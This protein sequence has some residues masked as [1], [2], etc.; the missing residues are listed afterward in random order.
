MNIAEINDETTTV[1][2][3]EK[4]PSANPAD[5]QSLLAGYTEPAK[6]EQPLTPPTTPAPSPMPVG[7]GP[8]SWHGNPMYYQTGKKAGQ[9][10]PQRKQSFLQQPANV[11]VNPGVSEISGSII[12]GAL[13]LTIINLLFPMLFSVVNNMVSKKKI[14]FEDL[15]IDDKTLKQLD[16]LS[17]KA[18]K[19]I[20]IEANPVAVLLVTMV[21][22][23]AMQ[24]MTVRM[25]NDIEAKNKM[26]V[27]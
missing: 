14:A 19:H 22:L 1:T 6:V 26:K 18:L 2:E 13:F 27:A 20:K 11:S 24:F 23:Y 8:A 21:G 7:H 5:L 12:S 3:P 10:K 9:L 25:I 4:T 15:Q 16:E 17:D